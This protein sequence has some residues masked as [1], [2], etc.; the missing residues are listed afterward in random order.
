MLDQVKKETFTCER[1]YASC[2]YCARRAALYECKRDANFVI[3]PLCLGYA[4]GNF[5]GE[6]E[7]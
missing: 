3:G 6:T 1:K 7:R 5:G 2:I 4:L